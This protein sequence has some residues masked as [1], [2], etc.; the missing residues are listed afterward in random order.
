MAVGG[1]RNYYQVLGVERNANSNE[2]KSAF[3]KLA[4]EYH[5]D[6]N[7]GDKNSEA[8]F[9][10]ITE[11]YEVLSDPEKKRRYEQYGQYWNK[12]GGMPGGGG[13][14]GF[15]V[16]FGNYGNFDEFINDL[17][18]R[19]GGVGASSGF[20]E[21]TG[22]SSR[23]Y[24]NQIDL[25]AEITLKISFSEAF[26][27]TERTLAVDGER[28]QVKIPSGIRSASKLRLKNKGNLQ[29]G[30]GRRGDLYINIEVSTHSVWQFDGDSLKAE[31]PI[32]LDE[33]LLGGN[34]TAMT[35]DGEAQ[36]NIPSG[37]LPGQTLRLKGKGWP[38]KNGRGDLLLIPKLQLPEKWS[39]QELDL[40]EKLKSLRGNQDPRKDWLHSARL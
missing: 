31:L 34:V 5:P 28:V 40:L 17:L 26:H 18:G 14:P 3:R 6:V 10:E 38:Y 13:V 37:I 11:A 36:V 35:P 39:S 9:K 21:N 32:S 12:S 30:T 19:F 8:K 1:Y 27:G 22:F 23:N 29:P 24:K 15:D 16:D 20:T 25:D 4:R 33:L 7:P 2:I